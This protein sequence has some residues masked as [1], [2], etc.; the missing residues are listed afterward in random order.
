[1]RA[2]TKDDLEVLSKFFTEWVIYQVA[3]LGFVFD[4]EVFKHHLLGMIAENNVLVL[5]ADDKIVGGIAGRIVGSFYSKDIIFDVMTMYIDPD[6]RKFTN[7]ALES[8]EKILE[9]TTVTKVVMANPAFIDST[10]HLRYYKMKGYHL[11]QMSLIKDIKHPG[12]PACQPA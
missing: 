4:E 9:L 5:E 1:M 8:L 3:V 2:A 10:K 11:L 7:Q 6:Y 12:V